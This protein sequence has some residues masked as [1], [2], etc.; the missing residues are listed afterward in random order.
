MADVPGKLGM[1]LGLES[2]QVLLELIF[3]ES[4]SL[5]LGFFILN[6]IRI[7]TAEIQ[8]KD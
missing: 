7:L 5:T 1:R 4:S 8:P 3:K 6:Q 2:V